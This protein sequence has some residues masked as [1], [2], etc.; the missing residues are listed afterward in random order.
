MLPIPFPDAAIL[1]VSDRIGTSGRIRLL[2]GFLLSSRLRRP[3]PVWKMAC[4][5]EDSF[6]KAIKFS[7]AKLGKPDLELKR[8]QFEAIRAVCV[9]R[10]DVLAVLQMALG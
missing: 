5:S 1:L 6:H 8:Q 4:T 2:T 10:K 7:L 3:E 9:E